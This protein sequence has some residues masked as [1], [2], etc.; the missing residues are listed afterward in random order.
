M[1]EIP[2][3]TVTESCGASFDSLRNIFLHSLQ[4]EHVWIRR[5]NGKSTEGI[6]GAPFEQFTSVNAIEEYAKDGWK[7]V[8]VFSPA[9]S[10]HGGGISDYFE[11]IFEKEV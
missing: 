4:A 3:E 9:V 2:W 11:I 6:Y 8:Q 5:L 1:A 7:L 10:A